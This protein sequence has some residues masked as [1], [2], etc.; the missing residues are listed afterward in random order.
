MRHGVS[1][2]LRTVTGDC[3]PL[4]VRAHPLATVMGGRPHVVCLRPSARV[5]ASSAFTLA[6]TGAMRACQCRLRCSARRMASW[7]GWF[8][9]AAHADLSLQRVRACMSV[10]ACACLS[11]RACVRA[12]TVAASPPTPAPCLLAHTRSICSSL[13]AT[14]AELLFVTLGERVRCERRF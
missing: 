12:Y 2:T 8:G 7:N 4:A 3:T 5:A 6:R 1:K 13:H 10:R 14:H 11:V 9:R